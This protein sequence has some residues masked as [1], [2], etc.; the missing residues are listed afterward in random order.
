MEVLEGMCKRKIKGKVN[1]GN[2]KVQSKRKVKRKIS[3]EI[4]WKITKKK[5]SKENL[6]KGKK[7][8]VLRGK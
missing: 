6:G 5:K 3:K 8:K 1:K 2:I 7:G 4:I